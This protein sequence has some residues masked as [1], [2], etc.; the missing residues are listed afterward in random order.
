L[1]WLNGLRRLAEFEFGLTG[2]DGMLRHGLRRGVT[3]ARLY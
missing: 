1:A 2:V 3:C